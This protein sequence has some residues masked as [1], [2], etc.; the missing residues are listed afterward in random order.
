MSRFAQ[1]YEAF[2]ALPTL[3]FLIG[4]VLNGNVNTSILRKFTGNRQ[5]ESKKRIK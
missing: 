1:I 2:R 5:V 4:K 3:Y